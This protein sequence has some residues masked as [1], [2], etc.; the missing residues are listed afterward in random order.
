VHPGGPPAPASADIS[1]SERQGVTRI[2]VSAGELA[3]SFCMAHASMRPSG[4][5]SSLA[6][7]D[8][9]AP[10][11]QRRLRALGH[12]RPQG[13]RLQ[14]RRRQQRLQAMGG[15]P[16]TAIR[17]RATWAA[18]WIA[19]STAAAHLKAV[20]VAGLAQCQAIAAIRIRPN[21]QIR[22]HA[23]QAAHASSTSMSELAGQGRNVLALQR[24][25]AQALHR[26]AQSASELVGAIWA[27]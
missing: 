22:G 8:P 10:V 7:A 1:S 11:L 17:A 4:A 21:P 5:P 2:S 26:T 25:G 9:A 19:A 6:P 18:M 12:R 27:S 13:R 16:E 20:P 24:T 14:R 15:L 3:A 23:A